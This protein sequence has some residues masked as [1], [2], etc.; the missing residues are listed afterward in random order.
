MYVSVRKDNIYSTCGVD[1][2][3]DL[4]WDSARFFTGPHFTTLG[5]MAERS[6]KIPV[7]EADSGS[8]VVAQVSTNPTSDLVVIAT[9][10]W[11]PM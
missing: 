9:H 11:G 2:C 6:V 5:S 4:L 7:G 3:C 1:E 10:P 8:Y